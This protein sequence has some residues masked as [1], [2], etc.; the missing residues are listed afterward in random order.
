MISPGLVSITFRKSSP[1]EIIDL[2]VSS[3]L[4]GIEWGGDIHVP[5]GDTYTSQKVRDMTIESGLDIAAYG[6]YYKVGVSED[7]GLCFREVLASAEALGAPVIRVWAG[8][9]GSKDVSGGY[10]DKIV[11]HSRE[12]AKIAED[13][14]I[15]IVFE[16]HGNTLTDTYSSTIDLL[17]RIDCPNFLSYWQPIVSY[18]VE[19]NCKGLEKL[20]PWV[21]GVH[22]FNWL[23]DYTRLPLEAGCEHWSLYIEKLLSVERDIYSLIE[24][25]PDDSPQKFIDDSKTIKKWFP[26]KAGTG[27]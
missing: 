5:H 20:L 23:A 21:R 12:I 10:R 2:V 16:F 6:S 13:N 7:E 9:Q 26:V 11:C 1:Q 22:C 4:S 19:K 24:F 14:G 8:D 3:G 15:D 27:C 18:S 17:E 25:V